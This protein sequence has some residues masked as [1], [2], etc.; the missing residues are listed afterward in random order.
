M[1]KHNGHENLEYAN[2]SNNLTSISKD[3]LKF[4][5]SYG[6]DF[7]DNEYFRVQNTDALNIKFVDICWNKCDLSPDKINFYNN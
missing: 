4:L 3:Y 5:N 2:N 1:G 6:K 7:G